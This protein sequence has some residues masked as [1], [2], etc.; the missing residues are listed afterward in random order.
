MENI[1]RVA[2]DWADPF[3]L[4]QTQF[5]TTRDLT[6]LVPLSCGVSSFYLSDSYSFRIKLQAG[7]VRDTLG[8]QWSPRL[9]TIPSLSSVI[10]LI[11]I[12]HL[13]STTTSPAFF[14]TVRRALCSLPC[15]N[16]DSSRSGGRTSCSGPSQAA[17]LA[18]KL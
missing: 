10:G 5:K 12:E 14:G 1:P 11:Q 2:H 18:I 13:S 6:T 15:P 17:T 9:S 3:C 8:N 7:I 16:S 4:Q